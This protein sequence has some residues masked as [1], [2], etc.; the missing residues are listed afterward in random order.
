LGGFRGKNH[1]KRFTSM[2]NIPILFKFI[3]CIFFKQ[4]K[5]EA[6]LAGKEGN[7]MPSGCHQHWWHCHLHLMRSI[8]AACGCMSGVGRLN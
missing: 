3:F 2:I 7:N 5:T 6:R 8:P 4:I 1:Q